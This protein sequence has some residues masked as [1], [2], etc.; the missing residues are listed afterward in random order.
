[1][2]VVQKRI[3]LFLVFSLVFSYTYA[4]ASNSFFV[5]F[6]NQYS[7]NIPVLDNLINKVCFGFSC[8]S[9][10]PHTPTQD[11]PILNTD[12]NPSNGG[13]GGEQLTTIDDTSNANILDVGQNSKDKKTDSA[14][15][16]QQTPEQVANDY[17]KT[18]TPK[19]LQL[20][21]DQTG[22]IITPQ[23]LQEQANNY[24]PQSQI[25]SAF[26]Q[27]PSLLNSFNNPSTRQAVE[28]AM[29]GTYR[30]PSTPDA[31][32]S[33]EKGSGIITMNQSS[34]EGAKGDCS[35][36]DS[37]IFKGFDKD[38]WLTTNSSIFGL[39]A[40]GSPDKTILPK[41]QGFTA[42]SDYSKGGVNVRNKHTC[43]VSFPREVQNCYFGKV[44]GWGRNP[45][46]KSKD[47]H[48]AEVAGTPVEVVNVTTGK[49]V[50]APL[51]ETGPGHDEGLKW[52]FGMDLPYCTYVTM[53][54]LD[55]LKGN[56]VVKYRPVPK[57]KQ[58]CEDYPNKEI[59]PVQ[60]QKK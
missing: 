50:V 20:I 8:N 21:Q 39:N 55:K 18:L 4:Q 13:N 10:K 51:W 43:I 22:K 2:K 59:A 33:Q 60:I 24:V 14:S 30:S 15:I 23:T 42:M 19:D 53:L 5:N 12:D 31:A 56:K 25:G 54:Q 41:Y 47:Q 29:N 11:T 9:A 37:R 16:V 48:Y 58:G 32:E 57:G 36:L 35:G 46:G 26:S 45:G 44:K 27:N 49:C 6:F 17:Y 28:S 38:G 3:L 7:R 40:N 52:G 1:M 34:F